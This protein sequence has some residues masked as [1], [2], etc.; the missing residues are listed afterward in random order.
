MTEKWLGGS[1]AVARRT[2]RCIQ[3]LLEWHAK[4]D[5]VSKLTRANIEDCV[6]EIADIHS[7]ETVDR[8]VKRI[9]NHGPFERT[10]GSLYRVNCDGQ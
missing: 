8:Y 7:E 9:V 6:E 10:D 3:A 2:N 4:R 5:D 1:G